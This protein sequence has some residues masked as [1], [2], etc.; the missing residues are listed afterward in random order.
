MS[1]LLKDRSIM[2]SYKIEIMYGDSYVTQYVTGTR[3]V[4]GNIGECSYIDVYNKQKKVF[5]AQCTYFC[6]IDQTNLQGV[7]GNLRSIK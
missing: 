5:S 2:R 7:M 3:Y 1:D 6:I 4:C